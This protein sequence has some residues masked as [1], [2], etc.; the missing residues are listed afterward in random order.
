MISILVPAL[1]EESNL[2]QAV[3]TVVAAA[4]AAGG[5]VHEIIIV[6]DGSVDRTGKIAEELAR[7]H[8]QVQCIH[9][10]RNQG[11]ATSVKEA[12]VRARYPKFISVPGSSDMD[13]QLLTD[14]FQRHR[15]ADAAFSFYLNQEMR[16][17]TRTALSALFGIIY[18]ATFNVFVRYVT[19][20][21]LYPTNVL[22]SM[23]LRSYG[24]SIFAE[25]TVKV[26]R[27]G[28]TYIEIPGFV[29]PS[30]EKSTAFSLR[31]F[32]EVVLTYGRL[33]WEI[34]IR[35]REK[36]STRATRIM[37]TELAARSRTGEPSSR[38]R[39]RTV[40]KKHPAPVR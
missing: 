12:L 3:E 17:R 27:S 29:R 14:L 32:L 39:A 18:M 23:T 13:K 7:Q 25:M 30:V 19:G 21:A 33:V 1:N 35:D 40:H 36:F 4:A 6:N 28:C 16:G 10:A 22:R 8:E 15:A 37:D 5:V 20:P 26:L 2:R 34:N 38:L 9:H 24:F 11:L 31:N